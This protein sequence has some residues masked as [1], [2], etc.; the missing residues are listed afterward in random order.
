MRTATNTTPSLATGAGVT[1]G[2]LVAGANLGLAGTYTANGATTYKQNATI[3]ATGLQYLAMIS[4]ATMTGGVSATIGGTATANSISIV[5]LEIL[6]GAGA[7]ALD[8]STPA[9]FTATGLSATSASFTPPGSSLLVL[10]VETNGN[11]V[12][13]ESITDTLGGLT[14]TERVKQNTSGNGYSGIWTAP[15]PAAVVSAGM[16]P[17][18]EA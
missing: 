1:T 15:V 11:L 5:L 4:A 8:S 18:W 13:T 14:W 16:L 9:G 7:L 6:K 17:G 3:G 12:V 2:S 10:A